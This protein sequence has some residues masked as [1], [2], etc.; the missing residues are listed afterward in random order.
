MKKEINISSISDTVI[1]IGWV[2]IC[3]IAFV[4]LY[5][6]FELVYTKDALWKDY[7]L[8]GILA[9]VA[10]YLIMTIFYLLNLKFGK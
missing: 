10:V 3:I 4:E 8:Y 1:T 2:L 7:L 5:F 6:G 9:L